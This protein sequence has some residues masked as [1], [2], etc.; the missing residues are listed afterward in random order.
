MNMKKEL[1]AGMG[2][3]ELMTPARLVKLDA[4]VEQAIDE[5]G[6]KRV[7]DAVARICY[8]KAQHVLENWQ[9][10]PLAGWWSRRGVVLDRAATK[11]GMENT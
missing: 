1:R 7:V 5:F 6:L 2:T 10:R 4:I 11:I 8:E 3:N 9:D